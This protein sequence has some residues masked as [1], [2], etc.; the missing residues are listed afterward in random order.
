MKRQKN[1]RAVGSVPVVDVPGVQHKVGELN[2]TGAEAAA[3]ALEKG[4]FKPLANDFA[5]AYSL[6][7][8]F[9]VGVVERGV[10]CLKAH[11]ALGLTYMDLCVH[12]RQGQV[13]PK[14]LTAMLL[15]MGFKKARA[16]E[17]NRVVQA[18][19]AQWS[20]LEAKEL[21]FK[22]AVQIARG[23]PVNE[24]VGVL[25]EELES[26]TRPELPGVSGPGARVRKSGSVRQARAAKAILYAEAGKKK[27]VLPQVWNIGN[28]Y[29]LT[30]RVAS[31][32]EKNVKA[33]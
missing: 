5:I 1:Q 7:V 19:E 3:L 22:L 30:L 13:A 33:E 11:K 24:V 8:E 2:I 25:E 28:G 4:D 32:D 27:H 10:R 16:S 6:P 21:G 15:A 31:G 20:L 29:V 9:A 23:A 26:H 14:P 17:V 18:T 12:L